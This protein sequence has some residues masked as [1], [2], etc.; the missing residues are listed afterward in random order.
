MG[1]RALEQKFQNC[2]IIV[3]FSFPA[4]I[5]CLFLQSD[6]ELLKQSFLVCLIHELGHGI[7]MTLT[8]AGIREIRFYAAGIRMTANTC[9]LSTV[10]MMAVYLSGPLMNLLCGVIFWKHEPVTALLHLSMGIFNLLPY[11]ILDGGAAL[12]WLFEARSD[13]L[14][15]RKKFCILLSISAI[16]LLHFYKILSP[17]LFLMVLYLAFC[18]ISVDKS[19]SL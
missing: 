15:I 12:E 7:V 2:R 9:L 11:R 5:A 18:E 17:A 3:E 19:H 13:F 10:Q 4:V 1:E 6:L 16:F 14:Q 8:G